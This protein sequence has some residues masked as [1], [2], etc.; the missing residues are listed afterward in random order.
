MPKEES[1]VDFANRMANRAGSRIPQDL[2]AMN[3]NDFIACLSD[4]QAAGDALSQEN[5]TKEEGKSIGMYSYL[6]DN[7]DVKKVGDIA[8]LLR[9]G[10][11]PAN[12]VGLWVEEG[13]AVNP[14][15]YDAIEIGYPE[16]REPLKEIRAQRL[17]EIHNRFHE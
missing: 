7:Y 1:S 3:I 5:D 16:Q 2:E 10:V 9:S 12:V 6:R 17:A 15:E 8:P 13:L 14:R 4:L 11:V